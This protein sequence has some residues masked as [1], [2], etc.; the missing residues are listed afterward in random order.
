MKTGKDEELVIDAVG[1]SMFQTSNVLNKW[2]NNSTRMQITN[3]NQ[4]PPDL[5]TWTANHNRSDQF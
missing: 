1:Y 5:I 3:L 2:S 4:K